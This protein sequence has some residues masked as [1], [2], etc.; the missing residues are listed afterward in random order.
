MGQKDEWKGSSF[1]NISINIH[2]PNPSS[3]MKGKKNSNLILYSFDS[4]VTSKIYNLNLGRKKKLK[5]LW[6]NNKLLRY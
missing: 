2:S 3:E 4:G 6:I 1:D 5:E